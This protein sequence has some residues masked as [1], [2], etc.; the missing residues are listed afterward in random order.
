MLDKKI[1]NCICDFS[2]QIH[3]ENTRQIKVMLLNKLTIQAQYRKFNQPS[4]LGRKALEN[5][6]TPKKMY[7]TLINQTFIKVLV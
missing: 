3:S 2:Y 6:R 5:K 1:I 4:F 7:N